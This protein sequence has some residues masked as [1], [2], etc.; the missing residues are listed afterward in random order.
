[1][2]GHSDL[3]SGIYYGWAGLKL[4]STQE[5]S[6]PVVSTQIQE[7][8]AQ[9]Q[10][11]VKDVG[12]GTA[13]E[14]SNTDENQEKEGEVYPMVMSLGYNP[15]YGNTVRSVEVHIMH[16]FPHYFYNSHLN[17]SI[18]G[19]IRPEYDYVSVELL[20]QDIK[21]D[22]EVAARSLAR[23]AYVKHK[24]DPYLTTFPKS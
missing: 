23:P 18:L 11:L 21:T 13:A 3:E 10:A 15:F 17:I 19:F 22:I 20:I 4:S 8:H 2:G 6:T 14:S 16:T 5:D 24:D 7:A 9:T 12:P 1:M